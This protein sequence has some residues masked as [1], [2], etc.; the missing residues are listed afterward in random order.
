MKKGAAKAPPVA[1]PGAADEAAVSERLDKLFASLSDHVEAAHHDRVVQVANE[2]LALGPDEDAAHC[3]VV[4][5]LHGGDFQ[6]A[7]DTLAAHPQLAQRCAV[8]RAY[9][10]YRTN[11]HQARACA[12][13]APP[14]QLRRG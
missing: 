5:L 9:C 12:R 8:E 14:P 13:A 1:P 6:G 7:L 4:A 11:A 3:K 10:L 2:I